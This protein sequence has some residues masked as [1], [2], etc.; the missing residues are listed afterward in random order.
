MNFPSLAR[1]PAIPVLAV[2]LATSF[3]AGCS[4]LP[5]SGANKDQVLQAEAISSLPIQVVDI[6][7]ATAR[8]IFAAEKRVHFADVFPGD[9]L[10]GYRVGAGD[11]VEVSIWEAPP[12]TLF[13]STV[14]DPR[15]GATT[16]RVTAFPEQMVSHDGLIN[17]PF[18]GMI[19]AA[20]KSPDR[21]SVV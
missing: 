10:L 8:R 14:L 16:T 7:D 9:K 4:F 15:A 3:L 17:I 18:A 6:D 2:A 11:V 1:V 12:A 20:G 21:K 5:S 13:G 19:P